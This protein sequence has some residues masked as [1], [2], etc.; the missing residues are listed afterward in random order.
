MNQIE[1]RIEQMNDFEVVR[2]FTYFSAQILG[3]AT[4]SVEQVRAGVPA[5]VRA[6]P[7]YAQ[8]EELTAE[9]A[10]ITLS[11]EIAAET[12]RNVLLNIA[13]DESLRPV[14]AQGLENYSDD[15]M[16]AETALA[17]G[18]VATMILVAATTEFEG[19]VAGIKFTK[20]KADADLVKAITEPF[21]NALAMVLKPVGS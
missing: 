1:D 5:D 12:A 20:G 13:R 4:V 18:F 19:E 2:F 6:A 14:L 16:V 21:A 8:I 17:I 10:E 15:E 3:G 9:Q 11:P 7:G